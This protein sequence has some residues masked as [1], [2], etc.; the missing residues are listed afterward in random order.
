MAKFRNTFNWYFI[1]MLLVAI[2]VFGTYVRNAVRFVSCDFEPSYKAEV[3]Y[4]VGLILPTF[5]A[6][7]FMD[8]GK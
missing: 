2:F 1:S 4:G 7:A 6:S 3:M 5:L 8:F